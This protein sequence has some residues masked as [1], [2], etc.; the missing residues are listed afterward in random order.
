M[1]DVAPEALVDAH[2]HCLSMDRSDNA[3]EKE[4]K[5]STGRHP[6]KLLTKMSGGSAGYFTHCSGN[7]SRYE[8]NCTT[9]SL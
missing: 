6:S 1:I 8:T 2:A 4:N 7:T 5:L 3:Q 9:V